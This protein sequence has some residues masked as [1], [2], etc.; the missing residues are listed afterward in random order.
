MQRRLSGSQDNRIIEDADIIIVTAGVPR[1]PGMSRTDVMGTNVAVLD[2]ILEDVTRYAP[3]SM[4][5]LV[6]NPVDTLTYRA[7]QQTANLIGMKFLP[8][9]ILHGA[10]QVSAAEIDQSAEAYYR[11]ISDHELD[12]QVKLKDGQ[13]LYRYGCNTYPPR[14][15]TGPAPECRIEISPS[16]PGRTD[17]FLH[18][19]T[20]VEATVDSVPAA[21]FNATDSAVRVQVGTTSIA[22]D[23][24]QLS[25]WIEI[26]GQRR[27]FPDRI[28]RSK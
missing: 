24:Q 4:L 17:Y 7:L 28:L 3:D 10:V 13:D 5:L 11:H 14:R 27:L 23:K 19:L 12:P 9:F 22:F 16:Q 25:G 2:S 20:A 15:D 6:S 1:K 18:V 26:G 21:V 8:A